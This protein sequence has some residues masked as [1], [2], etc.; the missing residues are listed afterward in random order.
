MYSSPPFLLV[1]DVNFCLDLFFVPY[2]LFPSPTWSWFRSHPFLVVLTLSNATPL[3]LSA[4]FGLVLPFL[5]FP[6]TSSSFP[7]FL[8]HLP[9]HFCSFEPARTLILSGWLFSWS[10]TVNSTG[11][12][13][14]SLC[15]IKN[16]NKQY[17]G[18]HGGSQMDVFSILVVIRKDC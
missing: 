8:T 1:K 5:F 15:C 7:L 4:I 13:R 16:R 14:N 6:F 3:L 12:W 10:R 17:T 2:S 9:T 11:H 18:L